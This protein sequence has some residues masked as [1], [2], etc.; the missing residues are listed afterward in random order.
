MTNLSPL[1]SPS[2]YCCSSYLPTHKKSV[3]ESERFKY[4]YTYIYIYNY[5][6]IY[7]CVCVCV[8]IFKI[9][10]PIFWLSRLFSCCL[11][12]KQLQ[13]L[14]SCLGLMSS[15]SSQ[16]QWFKSIALGHQEQLLVSSE[17]ERKKILIRWHTNTNTTPFG[18][19]PTRLELESEIWQFRSKENFQPHWMSGTFVNLTLIPLISI[20]PFVLLPVTIIYETRPKEPNWLGF[21][22]DSGLHCSTVSLLVYHFL[23]NFRISSTRHFWWKTMQAKRNLPM[24]ETTSPTI[25]NQTCD[26]VSGQN[27]AS[28]FI[29]HMVNIPWPFFA[30]REPTA[31]FGS[32]TLWPQ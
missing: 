13:L 29:C 12:A 28:H 14:E 5:K 9:S 7:I 21:Y 30:L 27:L 23:F 4:V 10:L 8:Y 26:I 20:D 16:L 32:S 11:S 24:K 18:T 2:S 31:G 6:Y 19:Y 22:T 15:D 1:C 17:L 3:V 25:Q